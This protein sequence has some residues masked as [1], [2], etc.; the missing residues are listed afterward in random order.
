M[1]TRVCK[2]SATVIN[3][4]HTNYAVDN[5]LKKAIIKSDISDHFP[6]FLFIVIL[7]EYTL[8]HYL[9]EELQNQC[10]FENRPICLIF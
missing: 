5:T 8:F 4:I 6:L 10:D 7:S 3:N 1:P 9:L 2:N